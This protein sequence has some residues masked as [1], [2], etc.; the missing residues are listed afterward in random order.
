VKVRRVGSVYCVLILFGVITTV[1]ECFEII[2]PL[3]LLN[4]S[5]VEWRWGTSLKS[6]RESVSVYQASFL[7]M[8]SVPYKENFM[9]IP[10]LQDVC[11]RRKLVTART[12]S[13]S[14]LLFLTRKIP[15]NVF[16]L[17][18]SSSIFDCHDHSNFFRM[19]PSGLRLTFTTRYGR[20]LH[21]KVLESYLCHLLCY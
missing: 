20:V 16:C 6:F 21:G 19:V 4:S 7:G 1:L 10:R 18:Y 3:S 2:L 5:S 14:R 8:D 17:C 11:K 15:I 13:R 9:P 12:V